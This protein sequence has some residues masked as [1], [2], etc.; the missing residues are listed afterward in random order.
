MMQAAHLR[1][2]YNRADPYWLNA[3]RDRSV[4]RQ[5]E[6]SAGSLVVIEIRLQ[7]TPQARFI[8][9]DHVIQTLTSNR[10]DQ[11]LNIG[12]LTGRLCSRENFPNA[13]PLRGLRE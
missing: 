13:E 8:Q 7:D 2:R 1:N 10:A 12:V 3:S 6:A 9:H 5:R 4:L 11:P